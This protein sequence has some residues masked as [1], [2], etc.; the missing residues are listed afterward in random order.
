MA[1][2]WE[3]IA[4]SLKSA[5]ARDQQRQIYAIMG[6]LFFLLA[7]LWMNAFVYMTVARLVYYVLPDR[8]I[9]HLKATQLTKLFVWID[10]LCFLVQGAGGSMMSGDDDDLTRTGQYIYV[11][12]CGA[13]L[14]C[15]VIFCGLMSRLHIKM[16][17]ADR[18]DLRMKLIKVLFW[19]LFTVLV[20]IMI[21]IVFRLIEFKPGTDWDSDILTHE[22][23]ALALD[24]TPML[25]GL[26]LLNVVH[27]GWVLRGP[28]SELPRTTRR[29]KKRIKQEKKQAKTAAKL[30]AK[31]EKRQKKA[32]KAA[33]KSFGNGTQRSSAD[34]EMVEG[35]PRRMRTLSSDEKQSY[36]D[37]V[38]CILN[39][40]ALTPH[41]GGPGVK[42]WDDDLVYTHIEQTFDL[43][44][45]EH[46]L[47]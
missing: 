46:F 28:E 44:H 33:K 14:L 26:L 22:Y 10:V 39:G 30:E 1:A 7:P 15:I 47:V 40:P 37:A 45:T 6:Q 16:V 11:G 34:F 42:S 24:A 9:W 43:H 4:F 19:A 35:G 29:E 18:V 17:R 12:G 27:P 38:Q 2:A 8:S 21:R 3:C 31:E 13:Q 5:G 41:F 25:L 32:A 20:F 23:Y 36:I